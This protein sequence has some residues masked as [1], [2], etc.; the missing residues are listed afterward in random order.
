MSLK[1]AL[2]GL[3]SEH[4]ASGYDLLKRF[5][6]S[7]ANV[8]P[9]TQSQIY[10]ELT[11]LA[12]SGLIT[13]AAEGPR[14]RKEYALADEGLT[15]LRHWLTETRPQ[16]NIRSDLLLRVFFLGVLPPERARAYLAQ[17]IEM[18]EAEHEQLKQLDAAIDWDD[19]DLSVYGRIVLEYGLRFN[20]M[21]REWAEW[22]ATQIK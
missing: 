7:L 4:P 10:T 9:A 15:E 21:R 14:G 22:A 17:L 5:E 6:T 20:A 12:G 18:S 3:L 13:V 8:W 11:K 19:D 1:H 2:L 16:R